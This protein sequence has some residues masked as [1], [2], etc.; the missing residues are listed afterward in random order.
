MTQSFDEIGNQEGT[1]QYALEQGLDGLT[2]V[3]ATL[4]ANALAVLLLGA[5]SMEVVY[6]RPEAGEVLPPG[7]PIPCG[8]D[9]CTALDST[10][11]PVCAKTA[12]A[13]FLTSAVTPSANSFLLFPWRA[14]PS[15]VT[16]VFGFEAQEPA[17][18]VPAH[19][20]DS[21]NLVALAVWSLKEVGRLRA[22]L[23]AVNHSFASRKLVERAKG[24]LQS[25]HGM[26]EQEAYEY[27]RRMSRQ[28]RVT[29]AK[30]AEDLL[31]AA[32]WP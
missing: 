20:S 28:R 10:P 4:G 23:R 19:I 11:G 18:A 26:N 14:R 7:S 29:L 1:P 31:G 3:A 27:L 21:L 24:I 9:V 13:R 8:L 2:R 6:R 17:H 16:I 12:V 32:R 15:G 30:L 25:E 5:T 22:E